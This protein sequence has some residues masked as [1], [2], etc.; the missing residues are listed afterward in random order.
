MKENILELIKKQ[1]L[2]EDCV[3]LAH[4]YQIPEIK[5]VA[6]YIGDSYY[7]SAL[8]S[9]LK[10]PKIYFCGV[11]FMAETAK[12]LSPDKTVILANP[13]AGCP[14]ADMVSLDDLI[15]FKENNP[16]HL[17]VSY[18][19]TS[20]DIKAQSDICVTSSVALNI[21]NTV[22]D[23]EILFLPDRNL[24]RYI[25]EKT[26]NENITLWEGFCPIHERAEL[27]DMNALKSKQPDAVVLIHPEC[28]WE[29]V[30]QADFVGST[31]EIMDFVSKS[32][33]SK[34][35]IGTELGVLE[36]L[37]KQHPEKEFFLLYDEFVC[38]NMKK[39][40]AQDL[41]NAMQGKGGEVIKLD[42]DVMVK[43]SKSLYEMIKRSSK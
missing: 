20:A 17:I 10:T 27:E 31:T 42:E 24:G 4:H 28:K 14:M 12:I 1:K 11:R 30:E 40:T 8:V 3:I 34:F 29:L 2:E 19:N 37:Q 16:N 35:I 23:K 7:L 13:D 25:K 6:D 21:M 39:T 41:L 36:S 9:K 32:D 5:Q 33:K 43:A 22:K 15:E 18:V 38:K 26:K